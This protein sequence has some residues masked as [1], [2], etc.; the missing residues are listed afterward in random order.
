M[1]AIIGRDWAAQVYAV[2]QKDT[3]LTT[4]NMLIEKMMTI[5]GHHA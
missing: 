2:R 1:C 3:R 5:Y 4:E